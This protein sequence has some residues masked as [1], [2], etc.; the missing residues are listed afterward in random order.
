MT[1]LK[2]IKETAESILS[3]RTA[4]FAFCVEQ[5]GEQAAYFATVEEAKADYDTK[6]ALCENDEADFSSIA[7][8]LV[9]LDDEG[10][11]VE[12]SYLETREF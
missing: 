1:T 11:V 12:T 5:D 4:K 10:S 7:L 6:I 2:T 8:E 3:E 9:F